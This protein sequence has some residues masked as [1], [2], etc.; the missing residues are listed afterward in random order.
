MKDTFNSNLPLIIAHR[1]ASS[2]ATE[3]TLPAF[4][5]AFDS[6]ADGIEFDIQLTKDGELVVYHDDTVDRL[7]DGTGSIRSKS[8]DQIKSLKVKN[9]FNS[10]KLSIPT[11]DEVLSIIPSRVIVNIEIKGDR[12]F[13]TDIAQKLQTALTHFPDPDRVIISSFNIF[14]LF[15]AKL[16]MPGIKRGLLCVPGISPTFYQRFF[17][18]LIAH[19]S[20]HPYEKDLSSGVINLCHRQKTKVYSYTINEIKKL[21]DFMQY[22]I[23]GIFTDHPFEMIEY[24]DRILTDGKLHS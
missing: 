4:Q 5:L 17:R 22:N 8:L 23:D 1:G 10:D 2:Q 18:K 24:R 3:N 11:L 12:L 6:G 9:R 15:R 13:Q 14:Q 19:F 20:L 21:H 16:L 7:T